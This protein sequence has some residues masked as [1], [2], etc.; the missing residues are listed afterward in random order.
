MSK[1]QFYIK[2]FALFALG[3]I[4]RQIVEVVKT[5][6]TTT[7]VNNTYTADPAPT[8]GSQPSASDLNGEGDHMSENQSNEPDV[9]G[10]GDPTV[11]SRPAAPI[12]DSRPNDGQDTSSDEDPEAGTGSEEVGDG[13]LRHDLTGGE[14]IGRRN[15]D[16]PTE[17][18]SVPDAN[19]GDES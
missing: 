19:P 2:V 6:T 17:N 4:G 12:E 9:D 7:V 11:D 1:R 13:E 10:D 5:S 3:G 16:L 14:V 18:L 8:N 15:E